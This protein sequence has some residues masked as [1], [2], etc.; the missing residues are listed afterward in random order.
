MVER[1]SSNGKSRARTREQRV[2]LRDVAAAAGLSVGTAS[3]A[4]NGS[5]LVRPETRARV[6]AAA[7]RLD[8]VPDR[9][10]ARLRH[11]RSECIAVAF[12]GRCP[13][14]ADTTFDA[15]MVRGITRVLEERGYT[16]RLVGL[17]N[18]RTRSAARHGR[19]RPLSPQEVD[20]LIVVN[21]QD[22]ARMARLRDVGVPLVAVDTSGAHPD[23]PSVDNDDRG[24]V[25]SG[26][27]YLMGLGH[28]RIA[29]LNDTLSSP[30]GRETHAGFLQACERHRVAVEPWLLRTSDF[31]VAGGRR[32]MA[33]ILAGYR[34]PTAVFAVDDETAVGAMQAIQEAGLRVPA[35]VSVVGM[36]DIPLAAAVRPALTTV[37]IDVEE[38]GRRAT[39][40]LLQAIDGTCPDPG[41]LVL[42][43]RLVVRDS[44]APPPRS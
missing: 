31:T 16:M 41:R 27:A 29:L 13:A 9:N 6:L 37:R 32:A 26:V 11:G 12:P 4:L 10:A 39:E 22:P 34:L 38:L 2:T 17:E 35:D 5:P 19:R 23:V 24:G 1:S 25:A 14:I 18:E 36:D 40:L 3:N 42:P 30:F 15:L 21:W 7:Q 33:E 20:G 8:Y 43:T 28:R 44:A